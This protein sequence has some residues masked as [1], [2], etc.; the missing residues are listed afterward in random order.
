MENQYS[1]LKD[2]E[3]EIKSEK[4]FCKICDTP[5]TKWQHECN[6][7]ICTFCQ[8]DLDREGEDNEL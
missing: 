5:I 7:D 6:D 2:L 8:E 4:W 1:T 3:E